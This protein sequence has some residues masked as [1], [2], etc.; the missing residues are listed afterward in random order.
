MPLP[1][2]PSPERAP[3]SRARGRFFS[4]FRDAG[5]GIRILLTTQRN[6]QIHCAAALAVIAAGFWF[7][8]ARWEW[9][10]VVVAIASVLVAEALN[11][12]IEFTVDLASPERQRLAGWAK[13][14]AAGAVLLASIFAA[15]IGA[16]VF[17]PHVLTL[18]GGSR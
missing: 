13:D 3:R 2:T 15:V 6:A 4:A 17:L 10:A 12:A 16:I 11:T 14:A 9:C 5:R 1:E 8:L 18:V 7:Q